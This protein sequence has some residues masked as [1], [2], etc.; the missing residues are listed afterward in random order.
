MIIFRAQK[1]FILRLISFI[2]NILIID[3]DDNSNKMD[4]KINQKK[5]MIIIKTAYMLIEKK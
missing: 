2:N 1:C 4:V 3:N 5:T